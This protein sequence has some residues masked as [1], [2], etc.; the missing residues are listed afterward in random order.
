MR[1]LPRLAFAFVLPFL[2]GA[3]ALRGQQPQPE[4]PAPA[5]AQGGETGPATQQPQVQPSELPSEQEPLPPPPVEQGKPLDEVTATALERLATDLANTREQLRQAAERGDEQAIQQLRDDEEQQRMQFARLASGL[6]VQQFL[7]PS[8]R[9]FDAQKEVLELLEPLV[10]AL[11]D[12]TAGP[13]EKS[14]LIGYIEQ[15]EK[16]RAT[17]VAARQRIDATRDALPAGS[18]ARAEAEREVREHWEPLLRQLGTDL[19]VA[20]SNLNRLTEAEKPFWTTVADGLRGFVKS[21]GLSIV[22]SVLA[23]LTVFSGLRWLGRLVVRDRRRADFHSRLAGLIA[24]GLALLLAIAATVAVPYV[25]N[26][27]FLLAVFLVFLIGAGW[28]IVKTAPQYLAE[29][30][31]MLNIGAVREG[32]RL[33][34][35]GLPYRV[36][37]LRFHTRL[38]NPALDG[39]LLRVPI[40]DLLSLRSRPNADDEPWFPCQKGDVVALDDGVIGRVTLQTPEVVVV[41]E[42]RDAPRNYPTQ[43]FLGLK[44]RNLSGGFEVVLKFG[45]DYRHL[46]I[47]LSEV[48]QRF[49]AAL[50][51]GL[52]ADI[53]RHLV[54]EFAGA[55]DSS[56]DIHVVVGFVGEAAPRCPALRRRVQTL[57]VEACNEHG[58]T[59]PFPQLTV[60]RAD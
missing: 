53:V 11:K 31:L 37:A 33:I 17:A 32:E 48:P 55:N 35:N 22:L 56:L 26:D 51:N 2:V 3:A 49:E 9:K 5:A 28:V 43:S 27:W 46:P 58:Y 36:D 14:N 6:D 12:A 44:P 38:S 16:R 39:G 42:R 52:D 50:K 41:A 20:R 59:I 54:V 4:Q 13:R 25:R 7:Q 29:F 15:L 45:V 10:Q 34:L 21:S 30:R 47:V 40:R 18:P 1:S 8:K 19:L 24:R 57:L 23:F 60:H